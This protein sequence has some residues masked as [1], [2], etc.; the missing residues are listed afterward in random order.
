MHAFSRK[1]RRGLSSIKVAKCAVQSNTSMTE[2]DRKAICDSTLRA[3]IRRVNARRFL[4][5]PSARVACAWRIRPHLYAVIGSALPVHG[6]AILEGYFLLH[7]VA[8]LNGYLLNPLRYHP[9]G[10]LALNLDV[11]GAGQDFVLSACPQRVQ[12]CCP[13]S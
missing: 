9:F 11:V 4:A 3:A 10:R 2:W 8:G 5:Y 1:I 6:Q 13:V 7:S 12:N